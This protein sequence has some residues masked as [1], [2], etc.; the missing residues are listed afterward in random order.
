MNDFLQFLNEPIAQR[1]VWA[2]ATIGFA[3]GFVSALVVLKR[4]SLQIGT[5]SCALLPGIALAILL[6]G[7]MQMS[8]LIGAVMAAMLIGLGSLF[9]SR[10]SRLDHDTALS[11]LHTTAFAAGYI[12]LVRLGLQ[13]KIDD[14]LFGSIMSMSDTDLITAYVISAVAVLSITALKRPLLIYL[15]DSQVASTLGIPSRLFSYGIFALIILVLV[16]S[17]Q[18][19]GAFLTLGLLVAPAA[20]VY[21]LTDKASWLFWG[22]GLIGG[23]GSLLAFCISFPLGWHLGAT[24]ILVLGACFILAYIFSPKYGLLK[25][26]IH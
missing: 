1:S 23:L 24:I 25:R 5:L 8:I 21:L 6:F 10:T 18:A 12:I 26:L 9:V 3:N 20:T 16:S 13:Q 19:V 22:G 15:F 11:I 17:L 14:W 2:C 7:F 4:S